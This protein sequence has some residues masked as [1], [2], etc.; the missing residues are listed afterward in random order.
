MTVTV[1]VTVTPVVRCL[2]QHVTVACACTK[3][4]GTKLASDGRRG[5]RVERVVDRS[6]LYGAVG[7]RRNGPMRLGTV[8]KSLLLTR[9]K[10]IFSLGL[11]GPCKFF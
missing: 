8:I 5:Q 2:C 10:Q 11:P 9:P 6:D 1:T 4:T 7:A 3:T